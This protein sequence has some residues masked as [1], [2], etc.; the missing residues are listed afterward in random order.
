MISGTM[1]EIRRVGLTAARNDLAEVI[2]P[3]G[4]EELIGLVDDSVPSCN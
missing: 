1:D 4:L 2:F 3:V